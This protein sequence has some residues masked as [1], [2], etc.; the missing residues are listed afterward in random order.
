MWQIN[1]YPSSLQTLISETQKS[2]FNM[3]SEPKTGALL[4]TL[5]AS[6][7]AGKILELGTGTGISTAWLL[8]GMDQKTSLVSVDNDKNCQK[9]A[10]KKFANDP[11]VTFICQDGDTFLASIQEQKFDLIFADAWPGKFSSLELALNLVKKGGFYI[12]DDLLPQAN[13]PEDHEL[14]IPELIHTLEDKTAFRSIKMEWSSGFMLLVN[15]K[16]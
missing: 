3:A 15:H 6:K 4:M 2:G 1:Q 13:W 11:R 5:A 16:G 9:I 10:K 7:P 8:H 14:R 12:I